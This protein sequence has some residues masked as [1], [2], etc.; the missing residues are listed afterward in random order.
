VPLA[1]LGENLLH[2]EA[3]ASSPSAR[4]QMRPAA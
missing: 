1:D 3:Q 2:R 4:R